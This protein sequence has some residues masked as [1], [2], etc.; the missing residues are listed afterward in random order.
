MQASSHSR[1]LALAVSGVSGLFLLVSCSDLSPIVYLP[2][3]TMPVPLTPA[4]TKLPTPT[5][6]PSNYL[7]FD[8]FTDPNSGWAEG[9]F[10]NAEYAYT[11]GSYTIKA[12]SKEMM[13]WSTAGQTFDD[14]TIEVDATQVDGPANDNTS[15]GI[16]CRVQE[17]G[18]GYALRISADGY[19]SIFLASD[20]F[21]ALID[22]TESPFI[23][24]GNQANQIKA[25]CKGSSLSLYVNGEFLGSAE[26]F[27]YSS[28]D[29]GL[30]VTTYEE[31]PVKIQFDLFRVSTP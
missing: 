1:L 28:G 23:R 7:Y 16:L 18:D 10:E 30:A 27:T 29:V 6:D 4:P 13:Q 8:N 2:T 19:Y 24:Q 12:I 9:E 21:S 31:L 3:P 15:Y 11:Q 14:A 20:E 26:D 5:P 17:N 25:I 22:W